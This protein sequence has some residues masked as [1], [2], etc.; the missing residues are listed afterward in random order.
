M[1]FV[2]I[3]TSDAAPNRNKFQKFTNYVKINKQEN[4]I[5]D[6]VFVA[7]HNATSASTTF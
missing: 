4:A 2:Q 1:A 5:V 3:D 7:S 6:Q